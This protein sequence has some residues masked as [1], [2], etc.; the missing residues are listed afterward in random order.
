MFPIN[1]F[2]IGMLINRVA[3]AFGLV[4]FKERNSYHY[5]PNIYGRSAVK[6]R[7]FR[8]DP[9]FR[10][11]ADL[12]MSH[13]TTKHY[14]DRLFHLYQAVRNIIRIHSGML[15]VAEVG[16]WKGGT[17]YFLARLFSELASGRTKMW[18]LDTFEGH[19][20]RDLPS[21]GR[22]GKRHVPGL[23][24]DTSVD[25]V[26]SYLSPFTFLK[27]VKGRVQDVANELLDE[28]FHLVH[29]DVDIYY[30]T[31]FSLS[32][33]G[34]RMIPGGLIIVDDYGYHETSPGVER[35]VEEYCNSPEGSRVMRFN[36]MT[37]QCLLV[38]PKV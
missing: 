7:D 2:K 12:V 37:G 17:S 25:G 34:S 23:F 22:E 9:L 16:V 31:K 29:L 19:D 28:R 20:T 10:D 32:F 33:F 27:V 36:L 3:R 38:I 30:P 1:S 4:I 5:V 14:Y 15:N 35:A 26:K 24:S 8:D 6:L 21:S 13:G 18:S 11:A